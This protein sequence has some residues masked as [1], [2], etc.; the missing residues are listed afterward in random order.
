MAQKTDLNVS[1]YYDDFDE[2][3]N[4]KRTLF[5]PGFA[6][7][8]RELTQL[9]STLQNQ[10]EKHSSH[11]FRE[12]AMV[13]PGQ[14]SYN[15][16]FFTLKLASTFGSETV[17]PSQYYNATTPVTITGATT[18]VTA[19]VIG[20]TA[21]TSTDQPLLHLDYVKT[22][23]D[24]V[25]TVFADGENILADTGITHTT[26]YS[27]GA[28][29]A[30]AF[31]SSFKATVEGQ[32][33]T[34]TIANL[35]SATGP[36]ARVGSA[37]RI[38]SGVYY[39][40][41]H[42]VTCSEETLVL[43]P[44][45]ANPSF[46]VGFTVT[47]TL[48]T[49]ETDT[50]LLDNA[51]GS[52]NFAAKGAH[53]LKISLALTKLARS[54][55]ADSSFVQLMDIKEGVIQSL[56]RQTEYSILEETL[57]RRTSEESGDYTIRPFQAQVRECLDNDSIDYDGVFQSR[58]L[59]T[60]STTDD[61]NTLSSD[62]LA[63]R[64]SP[65]KA[66]IKGYE[67]EKIA[68][69]IKDIKKAR[70]FAT[71][72]AGVT[73]F[74]VGNFALITNVYGSPDITAV[75]GE[76]TAF[77]KIELYDAPNTT[78][79]SA[80][81]NLIGV[82]KARAIEYHSG[83]AGASATNFDS[84]Y[85][86]FMF[87]LQ[88]F[89]K[90]TLSGTP[91]PT[92]LASH[93]SGGIQITGN[94]S[95]ATGFV[96]AS[97]T[98]STSVNL[99]GVVGA[100]SSGEKLIASDSALTGGLIEVSGGDG[101]T[102]I[103]IS[104]IETFSFVDFRQ[105]RMADDDSGQDFTADFILEE[106]GNVF[107]D[108]LLENGTDAV[109]LETT[110]GSLI[111]EGFVT[112]GAK[113]KD[114][115]KNI[116]LYKLPKKVIKT[117][118][119]A[120]NSGATDTQYTV[121]RQFVGTTNASGVVTFNA[122]TNETFLSHS[123]KDYTV[124]ILT[125][126][127][128]IGTST[129]TAS[130]GDIVSASTGFSAS[131][132]TLSITNADVFGN[133]AKVKVTATLLKTSVTQ[134]NKTVN[135]MKQLK[136]ATG[137]TDAFGTRP[138]D[139]IISL[140]RADVFNLVA[141]FDSESSS[142]DATTPSLTLTDVS[143]SFIR[144]EK[145]T[146][147]ITGAEARIIDTTSPM[148]FASSAP[149]AFTTS[150]TITGSSSGATAKVSAVTDGSI[151][152]TGR[153]T[154]DTGMR[155]NFYDISRLQIK[156]GSSLPTGRLLIVYDYMDHGS[157]DLL[158]VDSY[159]DVAL[160]MRYDDIPQYAATKVDPDE[161]KPTGLFPLQDTYDFRPRVAD[162]AGTSNT[163]SAVDEVTG[164]S[165]DFNSRVFSG[166]GSST[167]DFLK[168]GSLVQSD[169]EHYLP[170]KVS[171][172]L[173][174]TGKFTVHEGTSS[175]SPNLP[176]VPEIGLRLFD[177]FLPAYTFDP[178]K[179][180]VVRKRHQRF[181]MKDIGKIEQRLDHV[182][183]YT[184]LNMLERDA[185]SFETTDA[186]G[187]NRFKAGFVVDNF[188]GHRI[189]DTAHKDYKNSIDMENNELRPQ[190]H[191]NVN[192]L[193]E[194]ITVTAD[195]NGN[196]E[197]QAA[198]YRRTGR[199]LTLPFTEEAVVEQPYASTI[200][201]V[202]AFH[203]FSWLGSVFLTP[204]SD[205]WFETAV[206]PEL[207]VNVDGNFDAVISAVKNQTGTIWN[208]WESQWSGTTESDG[209][210]ITDSDGEIVRSVETYRTESGEI[211]VSTAAIAQVD[212]ESQGSKVISRAL[213]PYC[214]AK[215]IDF[216]AFG[217]KPNQKVYVYLAGY[218]ASSLVTPKDASFT[219]INETATPV[220]GDQLVTNAAGTVIGTLSIPNPKI[221]G[222]PQ[223]PAGEL[224]FRITSS[225]TNRLDRDPITAAQTIYNA[226]GILETTQE[227]IVS[228]KNA[229]IVATSVTATTNITGNHPHIGQV[230]GN[231]D[232][233]DTSGNPGDQGGGQKDAA[234]DVL[235]CPD[236]VWVTDLFETF[237]DEMPA[238]VCGPDS[239]GNGAVGGD[240]K[241]DDGEFGGDYGD[242][243][244]WGGGSEDKIICTAMNQMYGF[245]SFRNSIWMKY[246]KSHMRQEEYQ[247]G[248]HKLF[249]PLVKRM[250]TNNIIRVI[251]ERTAKR[252][253]INLRKEMRGQK[254][255]LYFYCM[256]Y[257]IRPL[258]F[259]VGWLVKKKILSKSEIMV[260]NSKIL[261]AKK[262]N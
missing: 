226:N 70:D 85:K 248:Y 91:S 121:R 78:R 76:T 92:L 71:V 216:R 15:N 238:D 67:V 4:F 134:K 162:I 107:A 200:E 223:F 98:S 237:L 120:T 37:V 180:I 126:G 214:R 43:D 158:S 77:K 66:Y 64:I 80:N 21:A 112:E 159:S 103:T 31:T 139:K 192:R 250:P 190:H 152:I 253:T 16:Q 170:K 110:G 94:T 150:D 119:T 145:I 219:P 1:P 155:D 220:K 208:S 154:L 135:L 130:Q 141:V 246:Q 96:F 88:P 210:F 97:G 235:G 161:S 201:R 56:V 143:G 40:R 260:S 84:Q 51:T 36:A 171:V 39:V 178:R 93:S 129:V 57:A 90:L 255:P 83:T 209:D 55:T 118:L 81:G 104:K 138:S 247:L 28:A 231:Y 146:G 13:V 229:I 48:V 207:V 245:G 230:N 211:S 149:T 18:G 189:G 174:E 182:E 86:L 184:A 164:N 259:A 144:G 113:L 106:L 215:D 254:L 2:T 49:P 102:D 44:Y 218:D 197:R 32:A 3:D 74:D 213:V 9:Q 204:D 221:F 17:D 167:V 151:A 62:L 24:N 163:L 148:S 244:A 116:S 140:G 6:I 87:D 22:G 228:T 41:G 12:G 7:Q 156:P 258:F 187:L 53:R 234:P 261:F 225:P 203:T 109:E 45:N 193:N 249:G 243:G 172:H 75:T 50:T 63:F 73:S 29:S 59:I 108:I 242:A 217:L 157:G 177:I 52:N 227:T 89:T 35:S 147:S 33:A 179:V 232:E 105:V 38:E 239:G 10:I 26:S 68:H 195:N 176:T 11:V 236:P 240:F 175:E 241:G 206:A 99:T 69:T 100:F 23:T 160:Q 27:S 82:G 168:P 123:E 117:L 251:L 61:G 212:R 122:Q 127:S 5:R 183:Y 101:S 19:Q 181:T 256:K 191:M 60:G 166:T 54:S 115:E 257:T 202:A 25:S 34:D 224:Q 153:Y 131:G 133:S 142:A 65:G 132:S 262:R 196:N 79:G 252:R 111:Q 205:E 222:N 169:F 185:E 198:G 186:N 47:E 128:A 72:N 124:S 136:V 114:T 95:G 58:S 42:F 165:F 173:G 233:G 194:S 46:R 30:T 199:L 125:A 14:M 188:D 137:T 8:A 20:F